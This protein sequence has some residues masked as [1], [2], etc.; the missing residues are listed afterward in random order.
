[1]GDKTRR[2]SYRECQGLTE[3]GSVR[4]YN[5]WEK[6]R[7]EPELGGIFQ[8]IGEERY[9]HSQTLVITGCCQWG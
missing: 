4:R 2:D 8:W 9:R 6:I 1:M 5:R 7:Q 3:S